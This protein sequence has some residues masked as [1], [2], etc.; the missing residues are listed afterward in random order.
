MSFEKETGRDIYFAQLEKEL[1]ELVDKR[2]GLLSNAYSR[3]I[4]CPLCKNGRYE[5]LFIKRGYT[6]VRCLECG[7]IYSNP[8][9]LPDITVGAYTKGHSSSE[10]WMK[11]LL[12]E[13]ETAW[14]AGYFSD[15]AE[16]IEKFASRGRILDVGC[17]VGHFL[18]IARERGW[19]VTGLELSETGSRYCREVLGL[20]VLNTRVQES[21]LEGNSFDA[22]S[23]LGVLEHVPD[24]CE[25]ISACSNLLKKDGVI[26]AVVPNVYSLANMILR[27][28]S[29]TFDGR[30]HLLYFSQQTLKKLFHK[31]GMEVVFSDTLLTGIDNIRRYLQYID[32]YAADQ[33]TEFL[34][35]FVYSQIASPEN[36]A[37]L[38]KFILAND[39]GLRLRIIA[40]P[41]QHG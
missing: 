12:N 21:G 3:E 20:P 37:E 7:L 22:I 4:P 24:P 40:R 15:I 27:E 35:D 23:L 9:V 33:R 5:Q 18:T 38:E 13:K 14:R 25:L 31:Q 34:P 32:P 26:V 30:N 2:T 19:D 28:K 17:A 6:F 39:L 29:V 36:K 41:L 10:L 16:K 8:Q 1:D 11:I